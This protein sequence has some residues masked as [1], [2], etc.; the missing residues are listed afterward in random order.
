MLTL[1][2]DAAFHHASRRSS[3]AYWEKGKEEFMK[4][5]RGIFAG[6]FISLSLVLAGCGDGGGTANTPTPSGG[7]TPAASNDGRA[8]FAVSDAAADMGAVT[9]VKVTIDSVKVHQEGAPG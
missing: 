9:S 7:S 5:T 1:R 6:V 3:A 4:A 2:E 8:V